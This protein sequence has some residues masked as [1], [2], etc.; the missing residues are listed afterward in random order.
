MIV[1]EL[2]LSDL[3]LALMVVLLAVSA[4]SAKRSRGSGAPI[5]RMLW[6]LTTAAVVAGLMVY[7]ELKVIPG[8]AL[9]VLAPGLFL[10]VP[11]SVV[12]VAA[13]VF[14]AFEPPASTGADDGSGGSAPSQ[15]NPPP[16]RPDGGIP[17]PDAEQSSARVRDHNR[18]WRRSL[19]SRRSP[20]EPVQPPVRRSG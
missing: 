12:V 20:R 13:V 14:A 2:F 7:V 5:R 17:L 15:P 9:V 4:V 6:T 8:A 3:T 19:P 10:A 18:P 11:L 16:D 1:M